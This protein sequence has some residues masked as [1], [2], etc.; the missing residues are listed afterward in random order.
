MERSREGI[1]IAVAY[2]TEML[3]MQS[4]AP[5]QFVGGGTGLYTIKGTAFLS[6]HP[7][8]THDRVEDESEPIRFF[9]KTSEPLSKSIYNLVVILTPLT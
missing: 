3:S 5:L 1:F 7:R 4:R 2:W 8:L 6:S 9:G